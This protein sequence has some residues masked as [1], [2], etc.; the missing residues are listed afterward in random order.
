M[1]SRCLLV[2]TLNPSHTT[3]S[4]RAAGPGRGDAEVEGA[5]GCSS[6]ERQEAARSVG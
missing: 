6:R 1:G 3:L 5:R 2:E 4:A